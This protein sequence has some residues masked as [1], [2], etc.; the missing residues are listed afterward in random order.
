[1]QRQSQATNAAAHDGDGGDVFCCAHGVSL[2]LKKIG[3]T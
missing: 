3:Q 1:M 2:V